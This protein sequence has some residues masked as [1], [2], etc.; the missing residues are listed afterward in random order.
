MVTVGTP[1]TGWGTGR[2]DPS[3]G[4]A[5]ERERHFCAICM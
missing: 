2:A 3:T 5:G 1:P 4:P